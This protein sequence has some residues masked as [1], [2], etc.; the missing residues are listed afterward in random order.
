VHVRHRMAGINANLDDLQSGIEATLR[1][2]AMLL[3]D[4]TKFKTVLNAPL[5]RDVVRHVRE[6]QTCTRDQRAAMEELRDGVTRLQDELRRSNGA[7]QF[8]AL[9]A[10]APHPTDAR[11]IAR[12][13]CRVRSR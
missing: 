8:A 12:R 11:Q 10:T 2:V 7:V 1:A 13:S 6:L 9:T 4:T 5:L 3:T